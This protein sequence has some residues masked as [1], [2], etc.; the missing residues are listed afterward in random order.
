M[1]I[2]LFHRLNV[3]ATECVFQSPKAVYGVPLKMG[4]FRGLK[5]MPLK[6]C[7]VLVVY[8]KPLPG[9]EVPTCLCCF[10]K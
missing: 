8:P 1:C 4:L 9:A 7:S 3:L 2:Q 10:R 5:T 6:Q